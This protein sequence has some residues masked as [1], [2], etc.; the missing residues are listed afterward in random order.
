[1]GVWDRLADECKRRVIEIV[2]AD[3][4]ALGTV[5]EIDEFNERGE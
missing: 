3:L 4:P 1:M 5:D 2:R